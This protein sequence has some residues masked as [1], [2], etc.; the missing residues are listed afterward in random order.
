MPARAKRTRR[1]R[2]PRRCCPHR[3]PSSTYHTAYRLQR[4]GRWNLGLCLCLWH[5]CLCLCVRV[6]SRL[7][8][9]MPCCCDDVCSC[10]MCG[11][12]SERVRRCPPT[13]SPNKAACGQSRSWRCSA[14]RRRRRRAYSS[15]R[16][17]FWSRGHAKRGTPRTGT[18]RR[19]SM[20]KSAVA[21]SS[22]SAGSRLPS[23]PEGRDLAVWVP[24]RGGA[25]ALWCLPHVAHSA[26]FD[27][28]GAAGKARGEEGGARGDRR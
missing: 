8:L 12:I 24:R 1:R 14:S 28:A 25:A 3:L 21:R 22:P 2:R 4:P 26:A 20:V 15:R 11:G 17:R 18:W 19:S 9:S 23:E 13:F 5:L 6:L 27:H 7:P 16:R 10:A